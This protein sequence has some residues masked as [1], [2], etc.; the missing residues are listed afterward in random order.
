MKCV[1][2][3][4]TAR[5]GRSRCEVCAAIQSKSNAR[6]RNEHAEAG[7]CITCGGPKGDKKRC[8]KCLLKIRD[9]MAAKRQKTKPDRIIRKKRDPL[10]DFDSVL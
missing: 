7:V 3:S 9:A 10:N 4:R 2:C 6:R 5:A 1:H 8:L